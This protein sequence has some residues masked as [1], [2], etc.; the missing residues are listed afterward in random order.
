M[1]AFGQKLLTIG[2]P[3]MRY[4][5]RSSVKVARVSKE[6][7][8]FFRRELSVRPTKEANGHALVWVTAVQAVRAG[9]GRLEYRD[10]LLKTGSK[11][12]GE[13]ARGLVHRKGWDHA[14]KQIDREWERA[15]AEVARTPHIASRNDA[16]LDLDWL[17]AQ[18]AQMPW[19]G[20][21]GA[22]DLKILLAHWVAANRAGGR[23]HGLSL[24]ECA[25]MAGVSLSTV[26]KGTPRVV[27][28]G[29]LQQLD[30]G[31][32]EDAATWVLRPVSQVRHTSKGRQAPGDIECTEP[33]KDQVMGVEGLRILAQLMS[34]DAFAYRGLGPSSARLLAALTE[35]DRP[36]VK[37]IAEA[38]TVSLQTAYR[39]LPRLVDLGLVE[40]T[41]EVYELTERAV[42]DIERARRA[43]FMTWG[44][45][46]NRSRKRAVA[47]RMMW[48]RD[49]DD[50]AVAIGTDGTYRRRRIRHAA[51][52]RAWAEKVPRVEQRAAADVVPQRGDEFPEHCGMVDGRL[53][54]LTTGL[55]IEH[56]VQADDGR[57]MLL[58]GEDGVGDEAMAAYLVEAAYWNAA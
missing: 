6:G 11:G 53:Y 37:D 24:R 30:P 14:V 32:S 42:T 8:Q 56:F 58:P 43:S 9:W 15:A 38:A 45:P 5:A 2:D 29:V 41:G 10:V 48:R 54:D 50:I 12:P 55:Q 57:L 18:Y 22:T 35:L 33:E 34:L 1:S 40:H 31:T 23:E 44:G 4:G 28:T 49:W 46:S 17:L 13:Y 25:E 26:V 7:V 27:A 16:S 19:R 52:R 47:K 3:E 39:H 20:Q 36:T 21:S 51:Q